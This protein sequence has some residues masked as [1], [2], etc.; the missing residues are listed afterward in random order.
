MA[1]QNIANLIPTMQ[2]AALLSHNIPQKGKKQN[3][4]KLGVTNIVGVNL[5][6]ETAKLTGSL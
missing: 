4:V 3:L 1:Y 5:I 2:S 6:R